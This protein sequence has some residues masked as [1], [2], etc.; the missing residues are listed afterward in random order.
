M[1]FEIKNSFDKEKFYELYREHLREETKQ[2]YEDYWSNYSPNIG[3][4]LLD[5]EQLKVNLTNEITYE[6]IELNYENVIRELD[7]MFYPSF[8]EYLKDNPEEKYF[9]KLKDKDGEIIS[10]VKFLREQKINEILNEL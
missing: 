8:I 4:G 6:R 1:S 3:N 7:K 5:I 10:L 9:W 2:Q